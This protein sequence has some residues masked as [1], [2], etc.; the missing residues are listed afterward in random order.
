MVHV[1]LDTCTLR[2]V[3]GILTTQREKTTCLTRAE[4]KTIFNN[5]FQTSHL[6]QPQTIVTNFF[7]ITGMTFLF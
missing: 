1:W 3:V 4:K 7:L 6:P 2:I 5:S